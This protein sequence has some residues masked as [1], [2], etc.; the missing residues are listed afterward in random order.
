M[1]LPKVTAILLCAAASA[2]SA[3]EGPGYTCSLHVDN[4]KTHRS[5]STDDKKSG[6]RRSRNLVSTET[7]NRTFQWPVSVSFS[8]KTLPAPG[9]VKLVCH[10][11]GMTEG[12]MSIVGTKTIPVTLDAK[13]A[14]KTVV[15]SPTETMVHKK[16]MKT[17]RRRRGGG[18]SSTRSETTGTRMVG[19]IMQ[20]M[21]NGKVER[22]FASQ[23][24]W[25]RH[26]MKSPLPEEEILK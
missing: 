22:A 14:L 21:V 2:A 4:P 26:A 16:T 5:S 6:S 25:S 7:V 24:K 8:G 9:S 13:G 11:V 10:F 19:C 20:L 15:E 23:S 1:K 18:S 12:R 17:T 3:A